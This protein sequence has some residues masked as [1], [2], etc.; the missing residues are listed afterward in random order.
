MRSTGIEKTTTGFAA[1]TRRIV[2]RWRHR[3]VSYSG[4]H[5]ARIARSGGVRAAAADV[6]GVGHGVGS[7]EEYGGQS[8]C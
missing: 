4:A 3:D 7:G 6:A 5:I 2:E 8:R 1:S